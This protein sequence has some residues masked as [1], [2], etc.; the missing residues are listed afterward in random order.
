M[1]WNPTLAFQNVIKIKRL[2]TYGGTTKKSFWF[3]TAHRLMY[4]EELKVTVSCNF[5]FSYFPFDTHL[6][7]LNFG[8]AEYATESLILAPAVV[9]FETGPNEPPIKTIGARLPFD[10]D[11]SSQDAFEVGFGGEDY[12]YSYAGLRFRLTRNNLGLL[13]GGFSGPTAIFATLS[14]ISF[15]ISADAVINFCLFLP[16][17]ILLN[18]FNFCRFLDEW[19]CY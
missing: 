13:M 9:Y 7:D 6:C 11:V 18:S 8:D 17:N 19:G 5:D 15:L 16:N 14:M 3:Q 2:P 4:H 12:K 1:L 10:F